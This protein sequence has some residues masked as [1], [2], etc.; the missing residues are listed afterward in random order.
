MIAENLGRLFEVGFN[1]GILTY[2]EQHQLKHNFGNLYRR[3]L[4]HL[5]FAKMFKRIVSED[6]TIS[7][8]DI[9]RIEKWCLYLLQKGFLSGLNF[10]GEYIKSTGWKDSTRSPIEILYYQCSFG[11][12]NSFGNNTRDQKQEFVELLSQFDL[13]KKDDIDRYILKYSGLG[14]G[15][16]FLY[17]DTLMLLQ[18]RQEFRILAVDLSIFSVKSAK[19]LLDFEDKD[20][21]NQRRLLMREISY[22]RSK[23]VFSKLRI[24][25][26][27]TDDF[28]FTFAADLT[29][30]FTAFKRKDKESAK[31][32]QAGSY[33]RSFYEFLGEIGILNNQ[34]SVVFNV[35]G[36]SDRGISAMSLRP[37][38][39]DVLTT[40]SQIYKN[41]P[42]EQEI[43]LA[44]KEVLN[45]IQ[46]N[47][48]RSFDNGKTFVKQLLEI[49]SDTTTII[50]HTEKIDNFSSTLELRE[51][52]AEMIK[53]VL[54]SDKTYLFLTGNPGIG[55]T[56]AIVDFL[57]AHI[58]EGFLFFYVSPRK[59]VNLDIIEKF[60]DSETGQLTDSRLFCINTNA[61]I[62][63]DNFR[64]TVVNYHSQKHHGDFIENP[65]IFLDPAQ[66]I[67]RQASRQQALNRRTEDEIEPTNRRSKGVLSSLCEAIY[68]TIKYEISNNIVATAC[69]Q[70]LKKTE[71]GANTLEHFENIFKSAYNKRD[72]K[73]IPA[74]MIKISTRIKHLFIMIDEITGD[75]SGVEFLNGI[76]TILNR[77]K[78]TD[79]QH[80]FNT[81]VIVADA[82]I[83]AP[84]VIKQH[85][86]E[87]SPEPD[88][89]FFRR[90]SSQADDPLSSQEFE[91]KRSPA[92]IINAN[93]Y[94]ASSLTITYKVFIESVKFDEDTFAEKKD[95]LKKTVQTQI[96][97]D[98]N[99]LWKQ[100]DAG[101]ILVYIQDKR[102]L[103]E[104]IERIK[105]QRGEF[106]EKK[107][108][109]E[110][111]ANLSDRDKSEIHQYKN[112][113]KV[114]FMTS[115]ASRGLSFPKAKHILVEIPRFRV[116]S[117]LMEIIQVI[118]RG[119]GQYIENGEE[120]TLDDKEKELIFYLSDRAIYYAD[121]KE[122]SLRESTI[123]LLNILLIVKTCVMT[124]IKGY[125][126]LGRE[127]FLMIPI[128]GKSVSAAGQ[129]FSGQMANLIKDLKN[130][131]RRRPSHKLLKEVYISLEQLLSRAEFVLN[132]G[133]RVSESYSYLKLREV[134]NSKFSQLIADS[135]DK[136]LDFSKIEPGLINGSLLVVPIAEQRLEETYEMRLMDIANHANKE[137]LDK[138]WGISKC[139]NYP[140]RLRSALK[141]AIELVDK[142]RDYNHRTQFLEQNN[143]RLDQYYALPLF[144]FISGEAMSEYFAD[145][146][147]EPEDEQFRDI[148]ATYIHHLYPADKTLPIGYK[149]R[150]FPFVVFS[151]YSLEE[152]REKIYTD[153]YLLT[154]N[155]LNV[156][157]LILSKGE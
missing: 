56:T 128:G 116:E 123:N 65:V 139:N 82:S 100:P 71:H 104:L 150:D 102:K 155:E 11:G 10:F 1:I 49:P 115:S 132:S 37:E 5:K 18:H 126:Q 2:I 119:R 72:G 46:L 53:D 67:Q 36:Y 108:Y 121:D 32:I 106:D 19:D 12:N 68:T 154:S 109:L 24:D 78:L 143:Q 147:E 97:Q 55:K 145:E 45:L 85:L 89:I 23:S 153:K 125:G 146:P 50:S 51:P 14:K 117:N 15:G 118:Y 90:A 91:F 33:A 110:I 152:M 86:S 111:H 35:V 92:I 6:G 84:D 75:D 57:K 13:L 98:I 157:N 3:D 48:G 136:L 149:Y 113:V 87:I 26:G 7:Q 144:T 22:L 25:T 21:Q 30:Y 120:K 148:L 140:S 95:N 44:R 151:S 16:E 105:K 81:K 77:Y 69:I 31:L 64:S 42:K 79:L 156:L 17:A 142:V 131:H 103:Q 4:Q 99:T 54:N 122:L 74:E 27:A 101:Q 61:E 137:L 93:S 39:L 28:S 34:S 76:S 138:M 80:G 52:H 40:C 60:T 43:D 96:V 62:I 114:I 59:Q 66:E 112:K 41:E 58:N 38:N 88:K 124:R 9:E 141:N 70:S 47:A 8:K 107:D 20:M 134:F 73:V 135:F 129:T 83:V 63:K 127:K 94:P 130:E 133:N 29:R